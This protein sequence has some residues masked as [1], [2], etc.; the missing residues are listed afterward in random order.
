MIGSSESRQRLSSVNFTCKV[1]GLNYEVT[2]PGMVLP[3]H[4][5]CLNL[6]TM[7]VGYPIK[8]QNTPY[9][10]FGEGNGGEGREE[11]FLINFSCAVHFLGGK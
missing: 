8:D 1:K 2:T 5:L 11:F 4:H 6:T 9:I 10:V 7:H 3:N